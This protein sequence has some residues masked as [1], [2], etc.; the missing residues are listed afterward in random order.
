MEKSKKT[1]S[2]AKAFIVKKRLEKRYWKIVEMIPDKIRVLKSVDGVKSITEEDLAKL[3]EQ[4]EVD[5]LINESLRCIRV[6][7]E[8]KM[9][10]F[11]ANLDTGARKI[12]ID[13]ESLKDELEFWNKFAKE[14]EKREASVEKDW[15][16]RKSNPVTQSLGDYV[17]KEYVHLSKSYLDPSEIRD[18]KIEAI[19]GNIRNLEDLLGETNSRPSVDLS[20]EAVDYLEKKGLI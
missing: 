9:A 4:H 2:L 6:H 12:M 3:V 5:L 15:D 8:L 18:F 7:D 13:I 17:T 16:S 19:E 10:I 1:I 20:E 14:L 11:K